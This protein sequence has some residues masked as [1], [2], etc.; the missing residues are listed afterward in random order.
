MALPRKL[1]H[2]NIFMDGENWIGVAEDFVLGIGRGHRDHARVGTGIERSRAG[3]AIAGGG[4]CDHAALLRAGQCLGEQAVLRAGKAEID[5]LG[6]LL[7]DPF[8]R[9]DDLERLTVGGSRLRAAE[10]A[11]DDEAG[12]R[13]NALQLAMGDDRRRHRGAMGMRRRQPVDRV[14]IT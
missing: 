6:A 10:G 4:D 3:A 14:E 1:K 13:R 9:G 5:H 7:D 12:R 11:G 2:G 8:E